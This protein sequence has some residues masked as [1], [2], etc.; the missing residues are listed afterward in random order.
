MLAEG[1]VLHIDEMDDMS[2]AELYCTPEHRVGKGNPAVEE[3]SI[4]AEKY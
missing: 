1:L 3:E 2:W 4:A